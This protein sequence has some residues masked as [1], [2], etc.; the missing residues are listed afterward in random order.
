M[1]FWSNKSHFR[2][3]LISGVSMGASWMFLF[4]AYR[5]I[6]VSVAMLAYYCG[7]VTVIIFS[8]VI[9]KEKI[10]TVKF[11]GFFAVLLGIFFVNQQS[12]LQGHI[13]WGLGFGILSAI[14]YAF[15]VIFNKMAASITGLENPMCNLLL[16]LSQLRFSWSFDKV[17]LSGL[18]QRIYYPSCCWVSLILELVAIFTF[19]PSVTC[20]YKQLPF[21]VI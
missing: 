12:L 16:V 7:P 17:F 14:I 5:Q 10:T 15:M 11:T 6:G 1:R 3:L 4:E 13:S 20:Q 18:S 8:Q 2:Y 9:F 21:L 19:L